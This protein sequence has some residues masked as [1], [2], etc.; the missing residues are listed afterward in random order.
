MPPAIAGAEAV[1]TGATAGATENVASLGQFRDM[2][3][4]TDPGVAAAGL[5][6]TEGLLCAWAAGAA[7]SSR[8]AD[9]P[10]V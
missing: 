4:I 3:L 9:T 8:A 7:R 5:T 2:M 1:I 10:A 6:V